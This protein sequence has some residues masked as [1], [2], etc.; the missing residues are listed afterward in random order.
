[1]YTARLT[2]GRHRT[3]TRGRAYEYA[4]LI[5]PADVLDVAHLDIGDEVRVR[6]YRTG[7]LVIEWAVDEQPSTPQP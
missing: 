1:M 7:R 6:I 5:I 2:I 3:K 4:R